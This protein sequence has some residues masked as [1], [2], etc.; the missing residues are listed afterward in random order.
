MRCDIDEL[1]ASSM[2]DFVD[3]KDAEW[4]RARGQRVREGR[5]Q[6]YETRLR[7]GDGT[8]FRAEIAASPLWDA[9][10]AYQG[11]VSVISLIGESDGTPRDR[12]P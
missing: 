12:Q 4:V 5:P 9:K 11:A 7:R 6:Q 3:A 2:L 8:S 1:M 10:G